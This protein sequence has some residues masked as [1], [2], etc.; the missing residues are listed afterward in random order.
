MVLAAV[1]D[2]ASVTISVIYNSRGIDRAR[3]LERAK[4]EGLVDP[5][6]EALSDYQ[7]LR[8]LARPGFS[9]ADAVTSVSGRGVGIDVAVTRIRALGGSIDI[10]TEAGEGAG[11]LPRPPGPPPGPRGPAVGGGAEA[12]SPPPRGRAG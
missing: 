4:H 6:T 8:V 9:T 1:R 7:L 11:F 2:G 10:R 3:I 12:S 5:H